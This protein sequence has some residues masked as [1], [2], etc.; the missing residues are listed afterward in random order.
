MTQ[1]L[2]ASWADVASH[3]YMDDIIRTTVGKDWPAQGIDMK[4]HNLAYASIDS[5]AGASGA[6]PADINLSGV[7][8]TRLSAPGQTIKRLQAASKRYN[9]GKM[10]IP[11]WVSHG[12]VTDEYHPVAQLP[13]TQTASAAGSTGVLHASTQTRRKTASAAAAPGAAGFGIDLS[14]KMEP[15]RS[16]PVRKQDITPIDLG[17]WE[18]Q[19]LSTLI[20]APSMAAEAYYA[21]N[22]SPLFTQVTVH[23]DFSSAQGNMDLELLDSG[24]HLLAGAYATGDNEQLAFDVSE[25]GIY[26]VRVYRASGPGS[27]TYDLIWND[28]ILPATDGITTLVLAGSIL[29]LESKG[30]QIAPGALIADDLAKVAG[31]GLL[32]KTD[33]DKKKIYLPYTGDVAPWILISSGPKLT[34]TATGGDV[35]GHR[36]LTAGEMTQVQA[37]FKKYLVNLFDPAVPGD[38][39]WTVGNWYA[40][41]VVGRSPLPTSL[42]TPAFM[43]MISGVGELTPVAPPP[44]TDIRNI[45]ADLAVFGYFAAAPREITG[46]PDVA[47]ASARIQ[48]IQ[49]RKYSNF[50][51]LE[52]KDVW[53]YKVQGAGYSTQPIKIKT[54][55]STLF[56]V[57]LAE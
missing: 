5:T 4:L 9:S 11:S 19:W 27:G 15:R 46:S 23:C 21:I 57:V 33:F 30:G 34:L 13:E 29:N 6:K 17:D 44:S 56:E 8:L 31:K 3:H 51:P 14:P 52:N 16:A 2:S 55:D 54:E 24:F 49:T 36:L 28:S 1:D 42:A 22:V 48:Q 35:K 20:G 53:W 41:G 40:G 10:H 26:Y 45:R 50:P 12:A 39:A 7:I 47:K 25:G 37:K 38:L 32:F 18:G 43:H